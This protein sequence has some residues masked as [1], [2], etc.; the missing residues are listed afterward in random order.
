MPRNL[1]VSTPDKI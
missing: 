1:E